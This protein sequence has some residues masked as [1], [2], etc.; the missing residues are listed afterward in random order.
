MKGLLRVES[1]TPE[2]QALLGKC[3]YVPFVAMFIQARNPLKNARSATSLPL[4][5]RRWSRI[6][7]EKAIFG[8][9]LQNPIKSYRYK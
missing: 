8:M 1:L 6:H 5:S 7:K 9:S 3:G 2:E 4:N